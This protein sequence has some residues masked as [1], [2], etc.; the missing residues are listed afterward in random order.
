MTQVFK[1]I[2]DMFAYYYGRNM[3]ENVQKSD[4]PVLTSTTGV[5]NAVYGA[6]AFSQLNNEANVFALM[7][8]L[9]WA[10]SGWRVISADAGSAATGGVAESGALPDTIKPTFAEIS[11]KPKQVIHNFQV[12]MIHEGLVQK[13]DDNTADMD[14]LRGYFSTLHGKRINEQMLVDGDTLAGVNFESIDRVTASAA[15]ATALSWTAADEDIYGID[16]SANSWADAIVSHASGTDRTF[17][18][19]LIRDT[20]ATLETKGAATNIL[21]TGSDT[22][23]RIIGQAESQVRYAGVVKQDE[24]IRVGVGGV[25]TE[26]GMN[27]GMR[28]ATV[29]NVPMFVSQAVQKDTLSRIYLLDTTVQDESAIPKL[30]IALLFPTIYFESGM[31]AADKNPY[32]IDYTGTKGMFYTAGEL[33][34][35]R[36]NNQGSIRDLK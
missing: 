22:K 26:E 34:C 13:G 30:F 8:K 27:Y 35:T 18:L 36:L 29:Y 23:W 4:A 21:L 12:S 24:K 2:G 25:S 7:P 6:Q 5:Y 32:S 10:K 11:T 14:F 19:S 28:V 20:L 1:T 16:R 3:G 31:S 33:I 9:P 17:D 15:L